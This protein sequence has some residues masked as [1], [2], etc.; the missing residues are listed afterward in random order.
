MTTG[1]G[2]HLEAPRTAWALARDTA[3]GRGPA[4]VKEIPPANRPL[5]LVF[6]GAQARSFLAD[7]ALRGLVT[8]PDPME[9]T[10]DVPHVDVR[11]LAAGALS[12]RQVSVPPRPC[13]ACTAAAL[14]KM[15]DALLDVM[16]DAGVPR[17][18]LPA[19]LDWL[20][21]R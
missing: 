7:A 19:L 20:A 5:V 6:L 10:G 21:S 8:E 12:G 4:A 3:A 9:W 13:A 1:W 2:D 15:A 14:G 18:G 17:R 11:R 16:T